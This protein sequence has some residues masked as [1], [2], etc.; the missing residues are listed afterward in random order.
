MANERMW[1][2]EGYDG[3][4][5]LFHKKVRVGLITA[6]QMEQL[7]RALASRHL[8]I[9]ETIGAYAT[10]RTHLA[11]DLLNPMT[12]G[13]LGRFSITVGTSPFFTAR[14]EKARPSQAERK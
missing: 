11:N 12:E 2:I 9:E 13:S 10:R 6:R 5:R 3:T 14:V 4:R 8:T 1:V 7:L